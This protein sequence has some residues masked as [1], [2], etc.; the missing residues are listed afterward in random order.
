MQLVPHQYWWVPSN[1]GHVCRVITNYV[2]IYIYSM[3]VCPC[4]QQHSFY[5]PGAQH[6]PFWPY[7]HYF[8]EISIFRAAFILQ[9]SSVQTK[10]KILWRCQN[11]TFLPQIFRLNIDMR[12]M[13]FWKVGSL[14]YM[15][16]SKWISVLPFHCNCFIK[17]IF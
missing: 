16:E 6:L 8:K 11:M 13:H 4:L 10:K 1:S 5:I 12:Q 7:L 3:P 2:F 14:M 9:P 15:L 17:L